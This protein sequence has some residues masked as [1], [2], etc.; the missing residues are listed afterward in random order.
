MLFLFILLLSN[1]VVASF[2]DVI[3]L[4]LLMRKRIWDSNSHHL[5][6]FEL[7]RKL[8]S[9]KIINPQIEIILK[10]KFLIHEYLILNKFIGEEFLKML[11]ARSAGSLCPSTTFAKMEGRESFYFSPEMLLVIDHT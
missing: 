10:A 8:N 4:S 9:S 1:M 11:I 6:T 3:E 5:K 7:F 2:R